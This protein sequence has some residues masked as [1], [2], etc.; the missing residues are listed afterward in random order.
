MPTT[1]G[2]TT[3]TLPAAPLGP[4]NPLPALRTLDE[5]HAVDAGELDSLPADMARQLGYGQLRDTLPVRRLDGYGRR[6]VPAHLPAL[7]IENDRLRAT[8]LPG[9]GGRLRSLFHKPSERELLYVNP[10][11]Q[12]ASFGLAGAWFSGGVEWNSGATGH[13]TLT[14]APLHAARVPAPDGGAMLRLWE[15]ERLRDLPYQVDI[16]LPEDSDFLYVGVR[17]RNPHTETRPVYWWSNT[18]VP[19][20]E[21]VRVLAPADEAWYFGY[22][23]RLRRVPVPERDGVDRSYPRRSEYPADYFYELP[24]EE[25]RWIAALDADGRGLVQTSTDALRGRKLFHWGHGR[26]GTQWQ[27]WLSGGAGEGYLEIQAGLAR[28]QLEHLPLVGGGEISWLEAYGPLAA[29]PGLV[30]GA[31]WAAARSAAGAA[32]AAVLPRER[33]AEAYGRWST[34]AA[35]AEPGE[36]LAKG[37]GW[38]ALEVER[39]GYELPGTPFPAATLGP[40]QEPWL[41]LVRGGRLAADPQA[42]VPGPAPVAAPW[43]KLL[44]E[45]EPGPD[46][47]YFLGVAQWHAGEHA[48]AVRT[49]EQALSYGGDHDPWTVRGLAVAAAESG[50]WERAAD[51]YLGAFRESV[52][53]CWDR[54]Y[55]KHFHVALAREAVPALLAV[56]RPDDADEVLQGLR[57]SDRARGC[58]QLLRAQTLVA[59]GDARAARAIFDAGFAVADLRE[60]AGVL[61]ETWFAIAE[62]LVAG[63]AE[64]TAA[65]RERARAEH[66]LP[67][68]YAY[69]MRPQPD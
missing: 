11:F 64:I 51:L 65:V 55:W 66:P 44:E 37:S 60:G 28:T 30:H 33:V 26:G 52:D 49:W 3:V 47:D 27:R 58:F 56:G 43:R 38:G 42:H 4:E 48:E 24:A 36:W 20:R 69:R 12:P 21:G 9:L 7:V 53:R 54:R 16:W 61:G 40:E 22:E 45:A 8:V 23:R 46:R 62:R 1:I 15:W 32:L 57:P 67:A 10:V 34:L 6:R 29:D 13:T 5:L 50:A 25:R 41:E 68:R 14:C 31:D 17:V 2:A 63:D 35:D 59:R 39:G 19:E 18:A